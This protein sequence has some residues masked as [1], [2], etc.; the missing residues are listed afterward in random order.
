MLLSYYGSILI[1]EV[2]KVQTYRLFGIVH[3]LLDKKR[4][5]AQELSEH[6]EVS[7]RTIL[8]DV[9]VLS[10][11]GIPIYTQQGKGGGISILDNY[12]L[13]KTTVSK[14]EQEHILLALQS[15]K[16]TRNIEVED[17]V[18]K[19]S[20]LFGQSQINWI[21]VDFSRWGSL[22]QDKEKFEQIKK[23]VLA[24][25][26]LSIVYVGSN[27]EESTRKVYPLKLV[28]KS[29]EWYLQAYC[30]EK[31]AY[32]IFKL[33]RIQ[34]AELEEGCFT[35]QTFTPP[36]I[37][38]VE[39]LQN[40]IVTLELCFSK[41]MAYRVYDEFAL[42]QIRKNADESLMVEVSYPEDTWLYSFLLSFGAG[43]RVL[44]PAHVRKELT[45][46]V[47]KMYEQQVQNE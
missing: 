20:Q 27:G 28:F 35:E 9:D 13:D 41:Q 33:N 15:F 21:E 47:K 38:Y 6:F 29:K 16:V 3:L 7:K 23:A 10:M 5:T 45:N 25:Q 1:Q 37:E 40:R 18:E 2:K 17:T 44:S 39:N 34:K 31:S 26:E 36:K 12:V 43:V 14:Q 32:R 30:T 4:L 46:Q 42:E 22:A 24:R 11:A 8:R 19:L